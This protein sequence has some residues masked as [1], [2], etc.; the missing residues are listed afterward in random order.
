MKYRNIGMRR[1]I[2]V[3]M[4]IFFLCTGLL[5]LGDPVG[6]MLI[7]TEYCKFFHLQFLL[8]AAKGLGIFFSLLECGVGVALISGIARKV[9]AWVTYGLIG[10]FTILTFILW[11]AN[12]EMDCG[13]FGE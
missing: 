7:V 11:R 12:P 10:F 2:A 9:T 6:T 8:P 4:G 3:L 1:L 5:K 13:C